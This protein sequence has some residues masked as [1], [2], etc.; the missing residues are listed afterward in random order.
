MSESDGEQPT[1]LGV[2]SRRYPYPPFE[3]LDRWVVLS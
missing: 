3:R 2:P 1:V